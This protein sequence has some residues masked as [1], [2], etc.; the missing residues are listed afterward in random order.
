M[1]QKQ[2]DGL[3]VNS[4]Y[5]LNLALIFKWFW[6]FKSA[7]LGLWLNVI[8]LSKARKDILITIS[9]SHHGCCGMSGILKAVDKLKTKGVDLHNFCKLVVGNDNTIKFWHDKWY[10]DVCFKEKFHTCVSTWRF[11]KTFRLLLSCK[12]TILLFLSEDGL[13]LMVFS[14]SGHGEFSVKSAR[15]VIDKHVLITSSTP[16]RWSKVL[17]VKLNVFMWR[18]LLDKLPTRSNLAIRGLDVP[19]RWWNIQIPI[20]LDP[21]TRESWLNSLRLNS[22]QILVLEA[23]FSSL[24]LSEGCAVGCAA[25]CISVHHGGTFTYDPLSYVD[26]DVEVVENVDLGKTNYERLMKIVKECCLFPVHEGVTEEVVDEELDDEIEMEDVSEYVGSDHVGEE[27]VEIANTSLT[28]SFLNMLVDGKYI[29]H[30]DFGA[31]VDKRKSSSSRNGDDSSVDDRYKH[32]DELKDCLINYGVANGYQLWYRRNEYRNISVL[33]GKNVNEGR[34]SS[35]KGKQKVVEDISTPNSKSKNGTSKKSQSPKT[36]KSPKTS[37][38]PIATPNANAAKKGCSFRLW[39]EWMQTKYA[40]LWD[41]KNEILSTNPGSTVQ[42]YVDTLDDGKTQ[43]KRMYICFKVVS[44]ENSENWLLFLSH[45]GSDFNIA[46]GAYLTIL[47]DGHK[48][49]K[50]LL[51]H[52]EHRLCARHI[53]A[54]FKKKWNGLHYKSLF[55]GVATSTLEVYFKHKME[56]IKNI[57]PLAYDR[58]M[59]RDPKAWCRAYFQMDRSCAAFENVA[60]NQKAVNLNDIVCPAIRKELEKL[61]KSQRYWMVVPCGQEFFEVRK[62]NEGFGEKGHNK[63]RC[64]NQTRPKPQQEKRKPGRKRKQGA[65]QQFNSPNADSTFEDS[66]SADPSAADSS[67]IDPSSADPS[68]ADPTFADPNQSFTGLLNCVEQQIMGVDITDA[69]IAALADMNEEEEREAKRKDV[70]RVLEKAKR[71]GVYRKRGAGG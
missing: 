23:S 46:M 65:N 38:S 4:L 59:E 48:A 61:K 33:C 19:C 49:V 53:Y 20:L 58:L 39:A 70:E 71:K 67:F 18:M 55:W 6:R 54:N 11:K 69:E 63:A 2:H 1:A 25:I 60:I 32:P 47:S 12:A 37:K 28:D 36:P 3:G 43:F 62:A 13:D 52:A 50:E 35:Q 10:D 57:D 21:S 24:W 42:L 31:K 41:Y 15:E 51:P 56:L 26:D 7:H 66:S 22:L 16:T 14:L 9:L 8:S 44:I 17:P 40:N 45:V 27:D 64:H 29:S 68:S 5:A 30:T 34:C